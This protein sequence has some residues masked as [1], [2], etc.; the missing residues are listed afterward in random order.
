MTDTPTSVRFPRDVI[1]A[2]DAEAKKQQRTRTWVIIWVLRSW[3]EH[4]RKGEGK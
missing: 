3:I 1:K 4:A 2:L